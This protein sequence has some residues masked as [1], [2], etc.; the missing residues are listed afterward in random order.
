MIRNP[1]TILLLIISV[2]AMFFLD[3]RI[4][5]TESLMYSFFHWNLILAWIPLLLLF[6]MRYFLNKSGMHKYIGWIIAIVWLLFFPNTF[7]L[8]TDYIHLSGIDFIVWEGQHLVFNRD[9]QV[10]FDLTLFHVFIALGVIL[11][12][13]NMYIVHHDVSSQFGQA[14]GWLVIHGIVILG[15]FGI[16][17]GRFIR[18]NSWDVF[19]NPVPVV[20]EISNT[21]TLHSL[22][23]I[24]FYSFVLWSLYMI[25]YFVSRLKVHT[26]EP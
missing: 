10:W 24:A 12:C 11:G 23:F 18:L 14:A 15:S 5:H 13:L 2:L 17:L 25:F 19:T 6:L 16:Y 26:H 20:T 4:R 3:L 7:Y 22:G 8:L 21:M 9:L 1:I